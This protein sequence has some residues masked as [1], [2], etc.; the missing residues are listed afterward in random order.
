[1]FFLFDHTGCE[2]LIEVKTTNGAA[3]PLFLDTQWTHEFAM[4][5]PK[6]GVFTSSTCLPRL[7]IFHNIA[8]LESAVILRPE[9]WRASF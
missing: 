2:R 3:N 5:Q 4:E 6:N 7:L 1:M 9:T 8:A